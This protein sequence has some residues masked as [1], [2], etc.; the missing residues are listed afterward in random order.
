MNL[1]YVLKQL[2]LLLLVISAV[3]VGV[4]AVFFIG[5]AVLKHDVGRT[6][7]QAL[8][9]TGLVGFLAGGVA[10]AYLVRIAIKGEVVGQR[11]KDIK[12][13][14]NWIVAAIRRGDNAWVPGADDTLEVGDTALLIGKRGTEKQLRK[15][16]AAG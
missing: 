12:L 3:L 10:D 13:S 9:I 8:F 4:A 5:E 7:M 16:F 15:L 6:A 11:L 14:P 1:R 2:G